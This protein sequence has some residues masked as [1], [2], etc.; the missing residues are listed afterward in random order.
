MNT[1]QST[2]TSQTLYEA[3][4]DTDLADKASI[5][6]IQ[7]SDPSLQI[8][9]HDYG[10]LSMFLSVCGVQM[11]VESVMWAAADVQ[12]S[13][14]FNAEVLRTHKLFPLSTISLDRMPDGEDYY[15]M[16]GALSASSS[17]TD[18]IFE[19]ET[20]ADNIINATEA[21]QQFLTIHSN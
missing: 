16:F 5:E 10:E 15:T 20:L 17:L 3:L 11:L 9:M 18:I 13:A 4:Q 21:Y 6:L 2:W 14:D 1:T 8:T 19:I 12:N 7:G